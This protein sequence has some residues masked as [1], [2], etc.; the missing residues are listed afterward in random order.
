MYGRHQ[1]FVKN[2][3][4]IFATIATWV[5]NE[6]KI[7]YGPETGCVTRCCLQATCTA[8]NTVSRFRHLYT[9]VVTGL[10]E[11]VIRANVATEV[12]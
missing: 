5:E 10:R 8:K 12:A 1:N 7:A 2:T 6:A 3:A 4:K 9:T 11:H